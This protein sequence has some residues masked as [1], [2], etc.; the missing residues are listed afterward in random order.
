MKLM[1]EKLP[2]LQ[3]LYAKEL[4]MLLSAEELIASKS[5]FLM[6]TALDEDLR[7]VLNKH[8]QD[9]ERQ[10]ARLREM[11]NRVS[12]EAGPIKCKTVYA[13]FDEAED[14]IGE[15]A[16]ES[17]RN[18]ALIAVTRRIKHYE[19]AFYESVREFAMTLRRSDDVRLLEESFHEE[20]DTTQQLT[21]IADALNATATRAA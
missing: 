19:L 16:H 1:V 6:E 3:A 21:Q 10:A 8:W 11:I 9:S 15:A 5:L 12:D 2:D 17:I 14:L 20:I 18:I 13:L 4:R 7:Q